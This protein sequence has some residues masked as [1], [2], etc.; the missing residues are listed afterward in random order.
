M[1]GDAV[2]AARTA[3]RVCFVNG[4]TAAIPATRSLQLA[5]STCLTSA[6]SVSRAPAESVDGA[7][8]DVAAAWA[9]SEGAPGG[10]GSVPEGTEGLV[11]VEPGC[12]SGS[13]ASP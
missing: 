10:E 5:R 4:E 1:S 2:F 3:R 7:E 12:T 13:L 6:L 8:G 11:A 9:V